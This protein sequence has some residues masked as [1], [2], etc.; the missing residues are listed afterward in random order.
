MEQPAIFDAL[1][2]YLYLSGETTPWVSWLG[3][4]YVGLRVLH[5]LVQISVGRV[6]LRFALFALSTLCLFGLVGV[7]LV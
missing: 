5:S 4:G 6:V 7:A 1:M 2:F 3:W